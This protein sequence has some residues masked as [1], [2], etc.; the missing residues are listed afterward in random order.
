MAVINPYIL[1]NRQGIPRL[2]A[3]GVTVSTTA[4]TFS[5]NPHRFLNEPYCG[6]LI[7]KLPAY[8]APATAVPIVF[9]TNGK[10]QTV[11]TY[12]GTTVTSSDVNEAGVYLFFYENGTLQLMYNL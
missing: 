4:A 2:E 11:T 12:G 7:V 8:T 10:T 9:S 3:T 6:L 1:A 5:F